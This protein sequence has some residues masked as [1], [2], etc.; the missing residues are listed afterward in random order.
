MQAQPASSKQS[1]GSSARDSP[2]SEYRDRIA[3]HERA[4]ARYARVELAIYRF[5]RVMIFSV[6]GY[7]VFDPTTTFLLTPMFVSLVP[8]VIVQNWAIRG[9]RREGKRI[10]F[11]QRALGRIEH[12]W[13]REGDRGDRYFDDAHPFAED[14]DIFG[15]GS[16]YQLLCTTRTPAG[17]DTLAEW[18]KT[19]ADVS[20]VV[21]R[22]AAVR[23]LRNRLDLREAWAIHEADA[24]HVETALLQSDA[25][26]VLP[27][28]TA[29]ILAVLLGVTLAVCLLGAFFDPLRWWPFLSF[30]LIAE[31]AIALVLRQKLRALAASM[32]DVGVG[33]WAFEGFAGLIRREQIDA[34]IIGSAA[35]LAGT[36]RP[37]STRVLARFCRL[38]PQEPFFV[39]LW[40]QVWPNLEQRHAALRAR[41]AEWF[42]A[43]GQ[44]EALSALACY[45]FEH[46]GDPFPEFL[47]KGPSIEAVGVGHPLIPESDCVRND[48]RLDTAQQLILISGSN[49]SGKSTLLR[50]LGT[51][52][53]LALAGAPVR[54]ERLA[55][56]E[57]SIGTAMRFRDSVHDGTSYFFAVV[58][59]LKMVT[60]LSGGGRPPLLFLFDE[61]LQGTN[62]HD[63]RVG[64]EAVLQMLIEAG[65]IGIVTTHDLT[66]TEICEALGPRAANMHF[67]DQVTDG[68]MTFDYKIKPGVVQ[69]SNALALMR[70]AGLEV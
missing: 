30:V 38:A 57:L 6:I 43:L 25:P 27:H 53:V 70:I 54:A 2:A 26:A 10:E 16:I 41:A 46:P 19:P 50:S 15:R 7:V 21:R 67:E 40:L 31:L 23:E 60:D 1:D 20:T 45:S 58:R 37:L 64:S 12:R 51:N 29:K 55:L 8:L 35:K 5:K 9:W 56:S 66:L 65:A 63:R 61:M 17:C 18:L 47:D 68:R 11:Y 52:A 34:S 69:K 36:D 14:L 39:W 42:A 32:R 44:F 13:M 4:I 22:Q 48:V 62:S 28:R 24:S 33:L 3:K 59:R 49:M